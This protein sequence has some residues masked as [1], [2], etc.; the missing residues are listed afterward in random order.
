M[1]QESNQKKEVV[2]RHGIEIT[3]SKEI[4][5]DEIRK[6]LYIIDS[7]ARR[8][9]TRRFS[10]KISDVVKNIIVVNKRKEI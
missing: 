2:Y 4:T 8:L 7:F 10:I 6:Y 3:F 9:E 1:S 5:P